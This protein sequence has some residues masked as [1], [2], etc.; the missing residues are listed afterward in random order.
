VTDS[1]PDTELLLKQYPDLCVRTFDFSNEDPADCIRVLRELMEQ[2]KTNPKEL[3]RRAQLG[4]E[5]I[6]KNHLL[7]N[8]AAQMLKA[9][10]LA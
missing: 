6:R 1:N 10:K 8:R 4:R 2:L 9:T 5:E 7:S 3:S